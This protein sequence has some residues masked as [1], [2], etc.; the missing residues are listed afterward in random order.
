MDIHVNRN[1]DPEGVYSVEEFL[2]RQAAG[3]FGDGDFAWHEGL[4][5]W[6]PAATY[7]PPGASP[8]PPLSPGAPSSATA[9]NTGR[10]RNLL[11][12]GALVVVG[13]VLAIGVG[14]YLVIQRIAEP[15]PEKWTRYDDTLQD[16]RADFPKQPKKE[17]KPAMTPAGPSQIV[18]T[19]YESNLSGN[20]YGVVVTTLPRGVPILSNRRMAYRNIVNELDARL[21][22][23]LESNGPTTHQGQDAWAYKM[24]GTF[25]TAKKKAHVQGIIRFHDNRV[26]Q[27]LV[28]HR[29]SKRPKNADFF[30]ES[31]KIP[32]ESL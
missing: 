27:I 28:V 4:N 16:F 12:I 11:V 26:Y 2:S 23:D 8:P 15:A 25:G 13:L 24:Y 22:V 6:Q 1:G 20:A 18:S 29:K 21:D 19:F 9:P 14:G 5:D 7:Q 30:F 10:K 31:V 17:T 32:N 3:Q